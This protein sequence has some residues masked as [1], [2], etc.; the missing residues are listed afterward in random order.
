MVSLNFLGVGFIPALPLTDL[1]N[2][3]GGSASFPGFVGD[4][5]TLCGATEGVKKAALLILVT[6][7]T[8]SVCGFVVLFGAALVGVAMLVLAGLT[9]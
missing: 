1:C 4:V 3:F 5:L 9:I 7:F 8:F 6:R 2:D